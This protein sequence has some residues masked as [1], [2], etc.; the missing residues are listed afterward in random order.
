MA[1]GYCE[2]MLL[3]QKFIAGQNYGGAKRTLNG[4]VNM[5]YSATDR[6]FAEA[7][8]NGHSRSIRVKYK[9][10]ST[11]AQVQTS[12]SCGVDVI[13]AYKETTAAVDQYVQLSAQV[14][15]DKIRLYCEDASRMVS[16][17]GQ[18]LTGV[19][20]FMAEHYDVLTTLMN[21]LYSKMETVLTTSMSTKFGMNV[22]AG[23]NAAQTVNFNVNGTT[24]NFNEGITRI[25]TDYQI[26]ENCGTPIIVGNGI[27]QGFANQLGAVGLN[28]YGVDGQA[29]A[30][31]L[32]FAFYASQKT[33]TT[34]GANKFGVFAP[35]SIHIIEDIR[36]AGNFQMDL[37]TV[38]KFTIIDP[39][40][41]CWSP[42]GPVPVRWDVNMVYNTC[43]ETKTGGYAGSTSVDAGWQITLF[44]N[45]G[46]FT[47]PTDLFDGGD[48]L[49]GDN[50]TL[51]YTATN[52]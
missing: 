22:R 36:N 14:T 18:S 5:L 30:D 47:P 24:Q 19:S 13:P 6:P 15:D 37:G 1:L 20:P 33:A 12:A 52:S 39:N 51:Y 16:A 44:K 32:G 9:Q 3:H 48:A 31:K 2:A 4:M 40:N 26:N 35:G 34:W 49:S 28:Q 46:L 8:T 41:T 25:L 21:G 7:Y 50:G 38:K 29:M 23:S 27:I 11:E 42:N 45:Y 43:T 10:R 17:D